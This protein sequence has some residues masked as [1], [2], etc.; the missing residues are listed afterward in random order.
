MV[1][2]QDKKKKDKGVKAKDDEAAEK[3]GQVLWHGSLTYY[4]TV[5]LVRCI[6]LFD[7]C[8]LASIT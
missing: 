2:V 7:C 5:M 8:L 1:F 6:C 4:I 3:Q